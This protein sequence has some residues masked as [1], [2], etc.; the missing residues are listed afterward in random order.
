M[1][2]ERFDARLHQ[3]RHE[4]FKKDHAGVLEVRCSSIQFVSRDGVTYPERFAPPSSDHSQITEPTLSR[5]T[6]VILRP[7]APSFTGEP[8]FHET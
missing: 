8:L 3:G 7:S 2:A 5:P 4:A 6:T 1:G